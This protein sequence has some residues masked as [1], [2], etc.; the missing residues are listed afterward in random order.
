[1]K[2]RGVQTGFSGHLGAGVDDF[3]RESS[4][5]SGVPEGKIVGKESTGV[6]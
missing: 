1:M 4:D 5:S 3:R 2:A 6:V